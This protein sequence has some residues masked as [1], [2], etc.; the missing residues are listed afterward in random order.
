V[1]NKIKR[2]LSSKLKDN[3]LRQAE[4]T[5]PVWVPTTVKRKLTPTPRKGILA[6]QRVGNW[7]RIRRQGDFKRQRVKEI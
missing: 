6:F 3:P 4:G 1:V 7:K 5:P 2:A